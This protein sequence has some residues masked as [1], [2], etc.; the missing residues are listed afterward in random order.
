MITTTP[1][2][3]ERLHRNATRKAMLRLIPLMC[4]IYLLSYLDRTN[5]AIAKN[6]LASQLGLTASA[7]GFGAG[8][9]FLAYAMLE[10]PSNLAAHRFGPR[11]WIVRIA[12]TWG[13]LSAAMMFVRGEYSFYAMRLL[14]GAAEAGL[15]PA[16][17]YMITL[18][19]QQRDRAVVVGWVY[20][21]PALALL[22]GNPVGGALMQLD[23][24][25][26]LHG[27]QWMFVLEGLPSVVVGIVLW[28]VLPERPRDAK[29]LTRSEAEVLVQRAALDGT[30]T[31]SRHS[32]GLRALREALF[33]P[34]VAIVGLI[35][36]FNQIAFIGLIFFTPAIIQQMHVKTPLLVGALSSAIGI[37]SVLGVLGVPHIQRRLQRDCQLLGWLTFGLI[38]GSVAFLAIPQI[39]VR[40]PLL[41]VLAFFGKGVLTL[42]WAIAM[43]RM[44]GFRAAAGLAFINMLGLLGAF[45]GPYLYGVAESATGSASSGFY[46]AIGASICGLLLV[47][48][49]R[50]ALRAADAKLGEDT[51][52]AIKTANSYTN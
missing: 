40:I 47:P 43:G 31:R 23:G 46:V 29:W 21:A 39:V 50:V 49:L 30:A 14:L 24:V 48:V 12:I 15:F 51:H 38:L 17:M 9:F 20:L 16:L 28:F 10:V 34:F 32:H 18:W 22:I 4:S 5:V 33:R 25:A 1:G 6:Q 2:D 19:F 27:W 7:Y 26:G 41:A 52:D 35:Y 45:L 13:L 36:F 11:R 8:I 42:Y 37:G 3:E 44:D